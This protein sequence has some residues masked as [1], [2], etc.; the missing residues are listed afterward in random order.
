MLNFYNIRIETYPSHSKEGIQGQISNK[1][2]K[3]T[4]PNAAVKAEFLKNE[5]KNYLV[6]PEGRLSRP[7]L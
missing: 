6:P 1:M 2:I 3:E 4:R 7:N 5:N